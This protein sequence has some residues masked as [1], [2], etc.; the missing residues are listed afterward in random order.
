[1][2]STASNIWLWKPLNNAYKIKNTN[3]YYTASCSQKKIILEIF[4]IIY[5]KYKR[6]YSDIIRHKYLHLHKKVNLYLQTCILQSHVLRHISPF[7]DC[8]ICYNSIT[9][10]KIARG[11]SQYGAC[12][13]CCIVALNPTNTRFICL[14]C[15]LCSQRVKIYVLVLRVNIYFLATPK[16]FN[17]M[18]IMN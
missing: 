5:D 16:L 9:L 6:A 1:M 7:L 12:Y 2:L 13:A 10:Q 15:K 17:L 8:I 4:F 3:I 18:F 14:T 11:F